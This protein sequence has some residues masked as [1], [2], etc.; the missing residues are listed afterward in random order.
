MTIERGINQLAELVEKSGYITYDEFNETFPD[1]SF[2]QDELA[3]ACV[4]P[5]SLDVDIRSVTR[6]S[7]T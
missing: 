5:R 3:A 2:S 4:K 6:H 1:Q 7:P